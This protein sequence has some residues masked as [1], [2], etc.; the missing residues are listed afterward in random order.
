MSP[1]RLILMRHAKAEAA[2]GAGDHARPLSRRGRAEGVEAGR[3]LAALL[4]PDLVLASD[5]ARSRATVEQLS[6][7]FAPTLPQ[8]FTR[9]LYGASADAILAEVRATPPE[10][11]TLLVVGH[12]PGIGELARR[13]AGDG[14]PDALATLGDGFPT[15][16]FAILALD[17]AV[18]SEAGAPGRLDVLLP[19][20]ERSG[21]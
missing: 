20:G 15:S 1:H 2:S 17:V 4:L 21:P 19:A 13:L 6:T 3:R 7:G 11:L 5:S 8:R 9:E 10:V 16:C 18:W 14:D 12:N